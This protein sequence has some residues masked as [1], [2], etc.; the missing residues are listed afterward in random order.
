MVERDKRPV[1]DYAGNALATLEVLTNDKVLDC[2]GVHHHD[3]GHGQD[4]GKDGG[5][6]ERRVFDHNERTL[7]LEGHTKFS[8][9]TVCWFADYL[10]SSG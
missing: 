6:E 5:R 9:E 7:V 3:V 2:S 10:H 4:L 8:Q 1:R